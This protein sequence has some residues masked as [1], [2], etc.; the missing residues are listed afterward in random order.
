MGE[1]DDFVK[2]VRAQQEEARHWV[3]GAQMNPNLTSGM[4]GHI[5]ELRRNHDQFAALKAREP[6]THDHDH[7]HEELTELEDL[8]HNLQERCHA[9]ESDLQRANGAQLA[10]NNR[11]Q[12][13]LHRNRFVIQGELT[14]ERNISREMHYC[15]SGVLLEKVRA[16]NG[17]RE[18]RIVHINLDD[19]L[20]RWSKSWTSL[21]RR[22]SKFDL[23]DAIKLDYGIAARSYILFADDVLPWL[24]F[25]VYSTRR[26]FDFICPDEDTARCFVLTLSRICHGVVGAIQTADKFKSAKGWCKVQY[27]CMKE[28]KTLG[29][30]MLEALRR[31]PGPSFQTS[32]PAPR[33]TRVLAALR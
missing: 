2:S 32:T 14:S 3:H 11:R 22:L 21:S 25:S 9:L 15:S 17:R 6:V 4:E 8:V 24:C 13:R 31:G 18:F 26:S 28:G 1:F 12:N 16:H 33:H 7:D 27:R 29:R 23:R 20:L 30:A 10:R 19:S 5:A